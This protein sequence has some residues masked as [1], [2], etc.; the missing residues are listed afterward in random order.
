[1]TWQKRK[2]NY[3]LSATLYDAIIL[4]LLTRMLVY[5]KICSKSSGTTILPLKTDLASVV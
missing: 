4:L 5:I 2:D 3:Y 1:M